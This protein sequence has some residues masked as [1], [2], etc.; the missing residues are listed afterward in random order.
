MTCLVTV[1]RS[2]GEVALRA[3]VEAVVAA[4][5]VGTPGAPAGW[6]GK[7]RELAESFARRDL[8]TWRVALVAEGTPDAGVAAFLRGMQAYWEVLT[9]D[10]LDQLADVGIK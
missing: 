5:R 10:L 4:K 9:E 7:V 2:P 6:P 8:A 3:L 1:E